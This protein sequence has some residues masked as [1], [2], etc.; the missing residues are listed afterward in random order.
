MA[1]RV[2]WC[3]K[4]FKLHRFTN[5]NGIAGSKTNINTRNFVLRILV[6]QEF[7]AC[8]RNHGL[9]ATCVIAVFVGV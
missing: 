6:R 4:R 8:R 1:H 5:L 7:S 3:I 2:A 9:V